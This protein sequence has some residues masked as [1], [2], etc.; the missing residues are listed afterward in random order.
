VIRLQVEPLN[1]GPCCA[2]VE[3]E[4]IIND[5][6][7]RL[8]LTYASADIVRQRLSDIRDIFLREFPADH[9]DHDDRYGPR[10]ATQRL[11][12][13]LHRLEERSWGA[14][15][16]SRKPMTDV[17]LARLFKG[18]GIRSGSVRLPDGSTPKG[19]YLR[20]FKDSFERYLLSQQVTFSSPSRHAATPPG[21]PGES[22]DFAAATRASC[23]GSKN[24]RTPCN[25]AAGGGVAAQE[26][27][28][29][30][31]GEYSVAA[32]DREGDEDIIWRGINERA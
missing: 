18:Y 26:P 27:E 32:G 22:E 11:L 24:A 6:S 28:K 19:Y 3:R 8:L 21:K 16:R 30:Q 4:A 15:G 13:E 7:P 14:W 20:S 25:S 5:L 2:R 10:L 23:G 31:N 9:S 12:K 1:R 29:D 17:Q